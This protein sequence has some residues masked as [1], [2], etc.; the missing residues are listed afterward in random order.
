[1][2]VFLA[3]AQP[4]SFGL[5]GGASLTQDFQ[6]YDLLPVGATTQDISI[7]GSSTPQ[8]WIAGGT[9]E[10][11]LPL[12][13]SVE[14]DALYHELQFKTAVEFGQTPPD[15]GHALQQH[16]VTWEFPVLL[17]YHF[18]LPLVKPFIA[19]GPVFRTLGNL[20]HTNPSNHGFA[21][22]LGTEAHLWRLKIAPQ[23]RYLRWARDQNV[24]IF[25]L[26]TV[27]D[28]AE[29]LTAITFTHPSRYALSDK[30][31]YATVKFWPGTDRT[32][33]SGLR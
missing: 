10:V 8:R 1:M 11:R 21:A 6:N 33:A 7:L 14:A 4:L 15:W 32:N 19:V 13:L 30:C 28:Q 23:F 27:T 31:V 9:L 26:T 5:I 20:S 18:Q 12:H 16:V 2:P 25:G 29:F 17:K 24:P 3:Y 22:G